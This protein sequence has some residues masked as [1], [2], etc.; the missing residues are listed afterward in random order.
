MEYIVDIQGFRLSINE[1]IIKELAILPV[2]NNN[3]ESARPFN[4]LF[5]P[6]CELTSIS[7]NYRNINR[8]LENNLHGIAW[9]AGNF[10]QNHCLIFFLILYVDQ[11]SF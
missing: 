5:Q 8:W 3:N 1:V 10:F 2:N 7:S 11:C 6:P 4:F 9:T